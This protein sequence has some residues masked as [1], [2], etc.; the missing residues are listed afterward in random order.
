MWKKGLEAVGM[1][2]YTYKGI[3]FDD[4]TSAKDS[5]SELPY[6]QICKKCVSKF[7]GISNCISDSPSTS[8][9]GVRGC[10]NESDYYIDFIP[11][12]EA[13]YVIEPIT[14]NNKE[15]NKMDDKLKVFIDKMI[16]VS[17]D[18]T[19]VVF[20]RKYTVMNKDEAL[21]YLAKMLA[22]PRVQLN[23][24]RSK[25]DFVKKFLKAGYTPED[26]DAFKDLKYDSPLNNVMVKMISFKGIA[27]AV[28]KG[29]VDT[30]T[31]TEY[32]NDDIAFTVKGD[33]FIMSEYY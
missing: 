25:T 18:G 27:E 13:G 9:C 7:A 11:T 4:F 15:E 16:E 28:I 14:V 32:I 22:I 33:Y 2:S 21:E 8:I 10:D 17:T 23:M 12:T 19:F 20:D 29:E 30:W 5:S 1:S 24:A 31:V 6:S 3:T 26:L